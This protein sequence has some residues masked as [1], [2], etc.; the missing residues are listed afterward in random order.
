M[1]AVTVNIAPASTAVFPWIAAYGGT[2]DVVYYA[3]N[4]S[5]KD[6]TSAVWNVYLA[7]TIDDGA[8]F[9]QSLVRNTPNHVG[10]VCT[11]GTGCAPGTRNLLDLFEVAIDPLNGRAG[12]IYTDD[13][14]MK[15]S[16]GAPLPQIVLA[17][18][19]P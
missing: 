2:V 18:Q 17:Q 15:D 1:P 6:D 14:L 13:T 19:E 8:S 3:T 16:S 9:A 4:A 5:S 11:N 12:I 10:V 7:Q